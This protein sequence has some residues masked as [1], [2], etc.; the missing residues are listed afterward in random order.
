MGEGVCHPNVVDVEDT[1]ATKWKER[2]EIL[3]GA[4]RHAMDARERDITGGMS[5]GESTKILKYISKM[6]FLIKLIWKTR[7]FDVAHMENA[8][9]SFSHLEGAFL[10]YAYLEDATLKMLI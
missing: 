8:D 1:W 2:T 5:G 6:Y 7:S 4:V 10:G 3:A 9:I